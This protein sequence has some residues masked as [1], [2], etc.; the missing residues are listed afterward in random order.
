MF[1]SSRNCRSE[2]RPSAAG[3]WIDLSAHHRY[4]CPSSEATVDADLPFNPVQE[5]EVVAVQPARFKPGELPP[6]LR[7][8][9]ASVVA[10]GKAKRAAKSVSR[11]AFRRMSQRKGRAPA[12]RYT[13]ENSIH[14]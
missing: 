5:I 8:P 9:A 14:C 7:A 12:H 6:C 2:S 1:S 3:V 13:I 11:P 10:G 4:R